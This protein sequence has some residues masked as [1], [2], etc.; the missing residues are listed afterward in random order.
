MRIRLVLDGMSSSKPSSLI[1]PTYQ[2][3]HAVR[4]FLSV[5]FGGVS[6]H[7]AEMRAKVDHMGTKALFR[8]AF[9]VRLKIGLSLLVSGGGSH[10]ASTT[11]R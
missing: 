6:R 3:V 4:K 9:S 7:R 2:C 10:D 11:R 1:Y 5:V 8:M